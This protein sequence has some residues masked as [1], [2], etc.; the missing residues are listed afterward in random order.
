MKAGVANGGA[1]GGHLASSH[2]IFPECTTLKIRTS[3]GFKGCERYDSDKASSFAARIFNVNLRCLSLD[4]LRYCLNQ[5][6]RRLNCGHSLLGLLFFCFFF[7][8]F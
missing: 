4:R 1:P 2:P 6:I 3:A 8:F 5:S 7:K